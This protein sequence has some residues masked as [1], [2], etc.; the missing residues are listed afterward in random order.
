LPAR[1]DSGVLSTEKENILSIV[2]PLR[3]WAL[4]S[5]NIPVHSSS[6]LFVSS[7][8]RAPLLLLLQQQ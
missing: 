1:Q 3:I 7:Y 4:E 5:L 2:L 8:N 6:A